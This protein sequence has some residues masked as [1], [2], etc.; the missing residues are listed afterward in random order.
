VVIFGAMG[1]LGILV[2]IGSMMT[3]SVAL[4]VAVDDT[5]H[6]LTWYR[7]GLDEGQDRKGA[8]L[9]AYERCANAMTQTT[10]IAGLGLAVFAFS[11]FT[12]TQRF[13]TLMLTLLFAALVGDL[14]F[15]PALL[16]GPIGRFFGASRQR[17][18]SSQAAPLPSPH[19][20]AFGAASGQIATPRVMPHPGHALGGPASAASPPSGERIHVGQSVPD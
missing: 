6:Y 15:L 12:P 20:P 3:A 11:S 8:A 9:M 16:C 17:G 13:G 5:I 1:W 2:D 19:E 14:V 18:P 7:R 10:L 4:G